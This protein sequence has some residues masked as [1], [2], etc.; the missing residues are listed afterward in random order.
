MR[1]RDV[2]DWAAG[3][4]PPEMY[5]GVQCGGAELAWWH[6]SA[7]REDTQQGG[8]DIAAGAVDIY[9]FFDQIS[10]M[11]AQVLLRLAGMPSAIL[12][13][14]SETMKDLQVVNVL[15]QRAGI[16]YTRRRSTPQGAHS[17]RW[18]CHCS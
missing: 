13:A 12:R 10:P 4:Q 14:Y 8:D 7:E 3:W 11:L 16:P 2:R 18:W 15:P 5:A 6:L 9:K 1:L 17:L